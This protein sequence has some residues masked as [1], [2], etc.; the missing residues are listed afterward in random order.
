MHIWVIEVKENGKW[1]P[2]VGT[3]ITKEDARK[4][5]LPGFRRQFPEG[6]RITKYVPAESVKSHRRS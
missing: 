3:G 2:T 5:E 4:I 1:S 6:C